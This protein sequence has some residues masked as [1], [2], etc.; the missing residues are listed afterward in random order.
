MT[1]GPRGLSIE[2][3]Q[4][5]KLLDSVRPR[6]SVLTIDAIEPERLE[7]LQAPLYAAGRQSRMAVSLTHWLVL[8]AVLALFWI[9]IL[10]LGG[11]R[12][13]EEWKA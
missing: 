4:I 2:G 8:H 11:A 3:L 5:E 1:P 9:W 7:N 12:A 6:Q 10:C 13:I